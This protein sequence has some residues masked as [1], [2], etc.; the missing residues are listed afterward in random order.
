M[1][2][3][4][5]NP[6]E[7]IL[8]K[9]VGVLA[10]GGLVILPTETVYGLGCKCSAVG[11]IERLF[12]IKKRPM[13]K[14]FALLASSLS[15]AEPLALD[16]PE[17]SKILA[18]HFFPGPLTL[19]VPAKVGQVPDALM[20]PSNTL[21]IRVPD[22]PYLLSVIEA[23][24]E[25][26]A[27]TSANFSGASAP[28]KFAQIDPKLL[29]MVDLALDGGTTRFRVESTVVDCTKVPPEVL[30]E[31]AILASEIRKVLEQFTFS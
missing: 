23:V 13:G 21:G 24:G 3:E 1:K 12:E 25:P 26:L 14:P 2:I 18:L 8:E 7:E 28:E 30:R 29:E 17:Q 5:G 4:R 15:Q 19:I 31:G 9:V 6:S 10:S 11:A 20:G 22:E 27:A 16:L